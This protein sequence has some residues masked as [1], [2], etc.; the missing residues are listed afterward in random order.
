MEPEEVRKVL[1]VVQQAVQKVEA[2]ALIAYR[3]SREP[4][5]IPLVSELHQ[6]IACIRALDNE[7]ARLKGKVP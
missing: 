5:P 1:N 6:A 2:E 4:V 3:R 7:L